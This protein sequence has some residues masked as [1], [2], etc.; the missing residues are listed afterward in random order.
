V[1]HFGDDAL[2]AIRV[3]M[4]IREQLRPYIMRQ[5]EQATRTGVPITRPLFYDFPDDERAATVDDPKSSNVGQ[6]S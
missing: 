3:V 5:Y 1:W 6:M 4:G 2:A